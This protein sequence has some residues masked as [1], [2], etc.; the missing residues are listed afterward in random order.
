MALFATE[1][2]K[3]I[4]NLYQQGQW[5]KIIQNLGHK[6]LGE[7]DDI[8]LLNDLAIAYHQLKNWDR[9]IE[10]YE[11]IRAIEPWPDLMKQQS[12]L[13]VRYMRY[14]AVMGEA[15]YRKGE[16]DKALSIFNDLKA[17]GSRFS[18]KYYFSG[19]IHTKLGDYRMALLEFKG[20]I[21]NVPGRMREV[22]RGLCE[23]IEANPAQA[24]VYEQLHKACSHNDRLEHYYARYKKEMEELKGDMAPAFKVAHLLLFEGEKAGAT[25]VLDS[26]KPKNSTESGWLALVKGDGA[27]HDSDVGGALAHYEEAEPLFEVGE[28]LI[29]ERLEEVVR[30]HDDSPTLRRKLAK[31]CEESGEDDRAC[32]HLEALVKNQPNEQ[33]ARDE[34]GR[35]L[36]GSM[37]KAFAAGEMPRAESLAEKLVHYFPDDENLTSQLQQITQA[38]GINRKEKLESLLGTGRMPASEA[39]KA[40]LELAGIERAMGADEE[41]IVS[42]LQ[43]A[44][45]ERS[46]V[47][48]DALFQLGQIHFGRGELDTADGVYEI[49]FNLRIPDENRLDWS[50]EIAQAFEEGGEQILA[51]KYYTVTVEAD[52]AFRD[53][54]GQVK[55][56]EKEIEAASVSASAGVIASAPES[57]DPMDILSKRYDDIKEL[58]RGAMGVVYRGRDKILD[59]PVAIK[60]ILGDLGQDSEALARFITEAQS[61]AALEHP[62][63]ITVYDIR[64]EEPMFIV[65]EFVE[66]KSLNDLLGGRKCPMSHFKQLAIRMCEPLAFA[67]RAEVVHRDIKPDNIMVTKSGGVKIADF[68]LS[69]KGGGSGETQVG[70]VMGTPYYMP[71][72]QI[73]G[74][75]TDGRSDIYSLG[76]TFY[77]MLTGAPPFTEGDIAYL[78]I[79]EEPPKISM[80]HPEVSPELEA[81]VLKCIEKEPDSRCQTVDELLVVLRALK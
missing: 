66:G 23:L 38:R 49:L 36:K 45:A 46:P 77:E 28:A 17:V 61:A 47:R 22:V 19:R 26:L 11:R 62:G 75:E 44:A 68:G 67:H 1:D 15:L 64:A 10:V 54:V 80:R 55:R 9:V 63:I 81:I 50:Y 29:V 52:S 74:T 71:P 18:D 5:Q 65:M 25:K 72:E 40:H 76:I 69:R 59:R 34:L 4:D 79:H 42:H 53:A 70:Q 51:M 37:N 30:R 6:P 56:L 24:G 48:A 35:L 78:H 33:G 2:I 58:G 39:A 43:K 8:R 32:R 7:Y 3:K 16:F 27:L 31:M 12:E 41:V 13:T 57:L 60:M 21:A 73:R 14:H 20:M